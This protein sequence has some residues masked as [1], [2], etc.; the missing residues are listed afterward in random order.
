MLEPS[1]EATAL[2]NLQGQG[3]HKLPHIQVSSVY[4][5][6]RQSKDPNEGPVSVEGEPECNAAVASGDLA[7]LPD[8]PPDSQHLYHASLGQGLLPGD[9]SRAHSKRQT[10][11]ETPARH[12]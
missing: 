2:P 1:W 7:Q 10:S 12:K 9:K 4:Q 11:M 6:W 8:Q 5:G 3:D